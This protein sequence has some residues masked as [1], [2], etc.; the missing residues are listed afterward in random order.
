MSPPRS[1]TVL[2]FLLPVGLLVGAGCMGPTGRL[3][4]PPSPAD[5]QAELGERDVIEAGQ[6]YAFNNSMVLAQSGEAVEVRP[7]FWRIRFG[8][9]GKPN[10][11]VELEFDSLARKVTRAQEIEIIPGTTSPVTKVPGHSEDV[12]SGGQGRGPIP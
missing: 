3:P 6:E 1:R 10:R 7:N 11:G 4:V 2:G 12:P 5:V 8:L 9:A